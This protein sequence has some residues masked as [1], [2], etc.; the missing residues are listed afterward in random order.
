MQE[1]GFDRDSIGISIKKDWHDSEV[2]SSA[3]ASMPYREAAGAVPDMP[4]G[5]GEGTRSLQS[6]LQTFC[7]VMR[8]VLLE[9]SD[10]CALMGS[11]QEKAISNFDRS[12]YEVSDQF[13]LL[14][15]R[16]G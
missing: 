10:A 4:C 15:E 14:A 1:V 16:L 9:Y 13:R 3:G 6:Q 7:R 8:L 12:E 11:G 2:F 5:D